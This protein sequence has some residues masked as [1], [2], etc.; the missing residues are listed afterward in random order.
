M[1]VRAATGTG[2]K[3][4][5]RDGLE[6]SGTTYRTFHHARRTLHPDCLSPNQP[7]RG[8]IRPCLSRVD[9]PSHGGP[10]VVVSIIRVASTNKHLRASRWAIPSD[11][12]LKSSDENP[13]G[14]SHGALEDPIPFPGL[15][16]LEPR[17]LELFCLVVWGA[18][19]LGEK[20]RSGKVPKIKALVILQ[21]RN[22]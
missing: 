9:T 4:S 5:N 21:A 8:R 3:T 20:Q 6:I 14:D 18:S 7:A 2:S 12:P 19:P 15:T 22:H 11:L 17:T 10:K 1:P 16:N 13:E